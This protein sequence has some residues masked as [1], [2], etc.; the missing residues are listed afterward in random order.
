[1]PKNRKIKI[2][3]RHRSMEM[4]GV[5]KVLLSMLN[6]L[7]Q[8]RF[9]I[10]LCLNLFQGE[11]RHEI[12]SNIRLITLAKGKE[13]FPKNNI[14][15]KIALVM[16]GIKLMV[17]R[18]FPIIPNQLIIKNNAD[19][20]IATGYTMFNDTINSSNKKSKKLGWFHSDI[21]FP[22]LQPVV[23]QILENIQRFDYM[24][25]GGHQVEEILFKTYP[26]LPYPPGKV[27]LNAIPIEELKKKAEE[28]PLSFHKKPVFVSVGRLH[29]RKGY[30]TLMEAHAKL[31]NDG[32]EHEI[33]IIGDGEERQNL[34]NQAKRLGV[35]ESFKF[36]GTLVNPYPYVKNADFYIMPSESEGWPLIIAE[37]L[38]L[39]KPII[40]TNVGSISQMIS[41]Q[42]NGY[43]I[44]YKV[45]DMYHSMKEFITNID[46]ISSIKNNLKDAEK[47]FDNQKIFDAVEEILI[48]LAGVDNQIN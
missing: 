43:L 36:L 41:H 47:Q 25:Y 10:S 9:D 26:N 45:D 31:L 19:I 29:S 48:D 8:E 38:I 20:E 15:Y 16:R 44:D 18:K 1:M 34:E 3:F 30:H 12:P 33:I 46:L 2:L 32:F 22:K 11:L 6:N 42:K 35:T 17:F 7:D 14:L 21:T 4:G 40:S 28:F 39:Q 27:I 5:E 37:A 13:D 24:I 23:P